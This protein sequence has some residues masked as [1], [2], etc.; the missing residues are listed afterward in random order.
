MKKI[1]C[2]LQYHKSRHL[3]QIY[4][5]FEKLSR[6]NIVDLKVRYVDSRNDEDMISRVLVN[7]KYKVIYDT[8]DGLNWIKKEDENLNLNK[9]K[10][11]TAEAD[12]YFK[13]SYKSCLNDIAASNCSYHPLGFNYN[14]IPDR[15]LTR[16]SLLYTLGR[17]KEP[18]KVYRDIV[19]Y[20]V[21]HL[22]ASDY[23]FIPKVNP[24]NK[25]LFLCRLWEFEKYDSAPIFQ[26]QI[27]AINELRI[28][29]I[30][31]CKEAFG[32]RFIGGVYD[33]ST[34][35]KYAPD[36]IVPNEY[37]HKLKFLDLI[38]SSNICIGTTGLHNSI[39]WKMGEYVAASRAIISEPL[40]Y[41]LPG[42]FEEG[43]NYL[44]FE[45]TDELTSQ[46]DILLCDKRKMT[47]MMVANHKYYNSYLKPEK[48]VLNTLHQVLSGS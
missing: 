39:G 18:K 27:E 24:E 33:N 4:S 23:E 48:L 43:T 22:T 41:E 37:T 36:L 34:S 35:H 45:N 42:D 44:K 31:A 12:F 30:R 11:L 19:N 15:K 14:V 21:E 10:E 7:G 20:K 13:R 29:S 5:G 6:H 1:L 26:S 25:I 17:F 32:E 16:D 46:I 2:E 40:H 3:N 28:A 8:H 47:D 9:F 38:K